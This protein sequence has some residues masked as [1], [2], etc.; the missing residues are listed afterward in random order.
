M[1]F[2]YDVIVCEARLEKEYDSP[3]RWREYKEWDSM[4]GMYYKI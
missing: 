2:L 3:D 1:I 4:T